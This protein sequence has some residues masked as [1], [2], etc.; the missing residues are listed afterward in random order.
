MFIARRFRIHKETLA[1]GIVDG[2]PKAVILPAEAILRVVSGPTGQ[3]DR[4]VDVMW[5]GQTVT[6]FVI[7]LQERGTEIKGKSIEA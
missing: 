3:G 4:M 2:E 5:D 6:M 7:D 1:V